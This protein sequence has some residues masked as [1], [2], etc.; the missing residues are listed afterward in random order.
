MKDYIFIAI[1]ER[2]FKTQQKNDYMNDVFFFQAFSLCFFFSV[3]KSKFVFLP[4]HENT[5]IHSYAH[6]KMKSTCF[7]NT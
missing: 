4:S 6:V 5:Y 3:Y 2:K 7:Y 1:S